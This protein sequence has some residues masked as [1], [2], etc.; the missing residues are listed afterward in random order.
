M[1]D[2]FSDT[3]NRINKIILKISVLRTKK[4]RKD[5]CVYG[6]GKPSFGYKC[7]HCENSNTICLD[8]NIDIDKTDYSFITSSGKL[9]KTLETFCFPSVKIRKINKRYQYKRNVQKRKKLKNRWLLKH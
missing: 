2:I 4:E 6:P 9:L 3:K 8:V 7:N 1:F 5:K